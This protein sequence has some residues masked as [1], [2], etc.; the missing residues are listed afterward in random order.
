MVL[1]FDMTLNIYMWPKTALCHDGLDTWISCAT[2]DLDL[3]NFKN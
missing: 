1:I 3:P 2:P